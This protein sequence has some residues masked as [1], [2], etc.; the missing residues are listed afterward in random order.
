MKKYFFQ[1]LV[2]LFF[3]L[4]FFVINLSVFI[5]FLSILT[6]S[7]IAVLLMQPVYRFFLKH[8]H[9]KGLSA[10]LSYVLLLFLI[11]L[12]LTLVV[13][14]IVNE[15]SNITNNIQFSSFMDNFSQLQ[16]WINNL[17]KSINDVIL[18][19]NLDFQ[20]SYIDFSS[21]FSS[22]NSS[23]FLQDGV[24][25]VF[26]NIATFSGE[27]IFG[28]FIFTLCTLFLFPIWQNLPDYLSRISPLSK[29]YDL[30]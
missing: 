10:F 11:I 16:L 28:F 27:F 24:L 20:L 5:R 7:Y 2:L 23:D 22:I 8:F 14:M 1:S 19:F 4:V 15:V 3:L 17:I 21:F 13:L 12:P 30:R 9:S 26:R 6:L 25:P 29:E 18:G